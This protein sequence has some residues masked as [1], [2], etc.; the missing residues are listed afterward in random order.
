[1]GPD[2]AQ[3]CFFF[4]FFFLSMRCTRLPL[5]KSGTRTNLFRTINISCLFLRL[6]RW[7]PSSPLRPAA[8]GRLSLAHRISRSS[9]A[10]AS[11]RPLHAARRGLRM[12]AA[13]ESAAEEKKKGERGGDAP[14]ACL[15]GRAGW[16][17]FRVFPFLYP[18]S[19]SFPLVLV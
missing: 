15:K 8:H 16:G 14:D 5:L 1:M 18:T 9:A 13:G 6:S 3:A 12:E 10:F 19:P 11:A 17:R 4:S 2:G 7:L